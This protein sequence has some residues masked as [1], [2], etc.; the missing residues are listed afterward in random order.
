MGLVFSE[1]A[2][3]KGKMR[4]ALR[5]AQRSEGK[6]YKKGACT[7]LCMGGVPHWL[8]VAGS[9]ADMRML[10][11]CGFYQGASMLLVTSPASSTSIGAFSPTH[12]SGM[13]H[14]RKPTLLM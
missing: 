2:G 7:L 3:A 4:V 5:V 10:L 8:Q 12:Q 6:G 13:I 11:I 14:D 1:R 9:F